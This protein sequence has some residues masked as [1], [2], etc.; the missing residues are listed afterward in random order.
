MEILYYSIRLKLQQAAPVKVAYQQEKGELFLSADGLVAGFNRMA[1][2]E[3][4]ELAERFLEAYMPR[5]QKRYGA[6]V[7]VEVFGWEGIP[8]RKLSQRELAR[9]KSDSDM[10]Q[11]R[12]ETGILAA[13][14]K[15]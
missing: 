2:L 4:R 1:H 15:P 11:K 14:Q 8:G 10:A 6:D 12:L 5:L 13:N 9:I 3:S 7:Q